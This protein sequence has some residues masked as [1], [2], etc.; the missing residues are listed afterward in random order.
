MVVIAAA[1]MVATLPGRT[2]GLGMITERLLADPAR[3][4]TRT[5]YA[6]Q[7]LAATLLGALFCLGI[8]RLI[9]RVGSRIVLPAVLV[10]LAA[11][12]LAM[13]AAVGQFGFFAGLT[14]TR[15]FGQAALS[16]VSITLVGKW[17]P[18]RRLG[19]AMAVYT[20]LMSIGFMAAYQAAAAYQEARWQT[21][22]GGM[23]V[24]LLCGAPLAWLITRDSPAACG[25]PLAEEIDRPEEQPEACYTF[26]EAIRTPAFWVFA[27]GVSCYGAVAAG[28]SIFNE[29]I[30]AD[31]GFAKNVYY[32]MLT[33]GVPCGLAA[34]FATGFLANRVALG[35]LTGFAF[36]VLGCALS[37]LPLVQTHTQLI[38]FTCV[39]A[40]AGGAVTVLFFTVWGRLYGREH[41]GKIQGLAQMLTVLG[42]AA[43][44]V[45]FAAA[46][47]S[48]GSYAPA[49]WTAAGAIALLGVASFFVTLPRVKNR[50]NAV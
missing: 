25:V 9:D 34:N 42:S 31:L 32:Q 11:S 48:G 46:H 26:G 18:R 16:V 27:I 1:A 5:G 45:A 44:P 37:T 29:A 17:F 13:T 20:V 15:G 39:N 21:V 23:G 47:R 38:A 43:G 41:L 49:V 24:V 19:T 40:A 6:N 14:G 28:L 7:N 33:L 30:F 3:G 4:L 36:L 2:H 10:L 35:R 12:V 50:V 22:W 8:G